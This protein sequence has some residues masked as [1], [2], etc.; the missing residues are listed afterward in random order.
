MKIFP[1]Y[2]PIILIILL[3]SSCDVDILPLA[4]VHTDP[5]KTGSNRLEIDAIGLLSNFDNNQF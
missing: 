5:D 2:C 3:G 4:D 1:D